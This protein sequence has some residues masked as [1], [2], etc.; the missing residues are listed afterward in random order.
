M[1][2]EDVLKAH[3]YLVEHSYKSIIKQETGDMISFVRATGDDSWE[4]EYSAQNGW[5][6][7]KNSPCCQSRNRD[8]NFC[9][10]CGAGVNGR[11]VYY[12]RDR[13]NLSGGDSTD[14]SKSLAEDLF[15]VVELPEQI[16]IENDKT[17]GVE[18]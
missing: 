16:E 1:A 17:K 15:S 3:L 2:I 14:E 11:D 7:E 8:A 9:C 4:S 5:S 6:Y 18:Y 13:F 10:D 12:H